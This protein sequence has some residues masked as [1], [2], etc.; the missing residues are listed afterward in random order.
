ML[1]ALIIHVREAIVV[2]APLEQLYI[3]WSYHVPGCTE[4]LLP[5]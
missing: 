5:E 3:A 4:I 2:T 1:I